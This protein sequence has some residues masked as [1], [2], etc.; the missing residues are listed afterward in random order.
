MEV[1]KIRFKFSFMSYFLEVLIGYGTFVGIMYLI[2][3]GNFP[4]FELLFIMALTLS[5]HP[6]RISSLI[7][8]LSGIPI[9]IVNHYLG[10]SSL[11]YIEILICYVGVMAF[12]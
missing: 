12:N 9:I 3:L 2:K 8:P 10:L 4:Y 6:W 1:K 11:T 7:L 5:M